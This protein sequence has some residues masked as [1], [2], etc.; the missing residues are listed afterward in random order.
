MKGGYPR[1]SQKAKEFWSGEKG[2]AFS[3]SEGGVDISD[4]GEGPVQKLVDFGVDSFVEV[5]GYFEF[6]GGVGV[7]EL[8][9][10]KA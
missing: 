10:R 8:V 6:G 5:E 2:R 7:V 3:F 9:G 4:L 1:Q